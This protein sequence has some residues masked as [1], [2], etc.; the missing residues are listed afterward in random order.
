MS[1]INSDGVRRSKR[2]AAKAKEEDTCRLEDDLHKEG[3]NYLQKTKIS[4][5]H[6]D[7]KRKEKLDEFLKNYENKEYSVCPTSF[8]RV[9]D[10]QK[11]LSIRVF[12]FLEEY[13][14]DEEE[15]QIEIEILSESDNNE[16]VEDDEIE[17]ENDE[18]PNNSDSNIDI[19]VLSNFIF[20]YY[21]FK[22]ML[23]HF[24]VFNLPSV[25][26]LEDLKESLQQKKVAQKKR[27]FL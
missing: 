4:I 9:Y 11:Q 12:S 1:F 25:D 18:K 6:L 14:S 27:I 8:R 10:K 13:E 2:L 7:E 16:I 23:V 3:I 20:N 17:S 22:E 26:D 15:E 5:A 19:D 24:G 21:N